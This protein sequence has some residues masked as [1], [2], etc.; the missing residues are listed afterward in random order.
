MTSEASKETAMLL[1]SRTVMWNVVASCLRKQ[2]NREWRSSFRLYS[3]KLYW[4]NFPKTNIVTSIASW[5]KVTQVFYIY[6]YKSICGKSKRGILALLWLLIFL[7]FF[8]F[9]ILLDWKATSNSWIVPCS[10]HKIKTSRNCVKRNEWKSSW[11]ST[12]REVLGFTFVEKA[13]WFEEA[14]FYLGGSSPAV[15]GKF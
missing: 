11:H 13:I 10:K 12:F 7:G 9:S 2:R 1:S 14:P 4:D 8:T 3:L 6:V 15:L 5:N